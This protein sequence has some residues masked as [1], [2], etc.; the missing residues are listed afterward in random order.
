MQ[1]SFLVK[2]IFYWA[3]VASRRIHR[4]PLQRRHVLHCSNQGSQACEGR[5]CTFNWKDRMLNPDALQTEQ[6]AIPSSVIW[7]KPM[8]SRPH[9]DQGH[10]LQLKLSIWDCKLS[11]RYREKLEAGKGG[12]EGRGETGTHILLNIWVIKSKNRKLL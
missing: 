4:P 12:E 5:R 10:F 3:S 2:G 9:L 11:I 8:D 1:Y 6:A 7:S